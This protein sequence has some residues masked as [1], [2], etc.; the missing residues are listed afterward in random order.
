MSRRG[1]A[2]AQRNRHEIICLLKRRQWKVSCRRKKETNGLVRTLGLSE[3]SCLPTEPFSFC[4]LAIDDSTMATTEDTWPWSMQ[5]NKAGKT[6]HK[7]WLSVSSAQQGSAA[8]EYLFF[9]AI[10][11]YSKQPLTSHYSP[12][13]IIKI[14]VLG[15]RTTLSAWPSPPPCTAFCMAMKEEKW[16]DTRVQKDKATGV[17]GGGLL[18]GRSG[19][20]SFWETAVMKLSFSV[21][22]LKG[23]GDSLASCMKYSVPDRTPAY[24]TQITAT[25]GA[26]RDRVSPRGSKHHTSGRAAIVARRGRSLVNSNAIFSVPPCLPAPA[27]HPELGF[28]SWAKW[29]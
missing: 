21:G 13:F 27:F 14:A 1:F 11:F 23:A 8:S 7:A 3:A 25:R 6:K 29:A 15:R 17:T 19:G 24:G 9:L 28:G 5:S 20:H 18:W 4:G 16:Q 12:S 10:C 22:S 26:H 2:S